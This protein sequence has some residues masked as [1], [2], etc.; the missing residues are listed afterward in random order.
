[1]R[2]NTNIHSPVRQ[3]GETFEAYKV[4]R[5][6]SNL[7]AKE[8]SQIGKGGR[9]TRSVV[10]DEMREE[11]TMKYMAGSYGKGLRNWINRAQAAKVAN[12]GK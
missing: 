3:E 11:G 10:R 12:K 6:E 7:Q 9:N 8:N 2:N 5:K 1:M 4:R